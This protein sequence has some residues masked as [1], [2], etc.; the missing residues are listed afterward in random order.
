MRG[1]ILLSAASLHALKGWFIGVT[2]LSS[3]DFVQ[4][5]QVHFIS[6]S[7]LKYCRVALTLGLV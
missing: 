5:K 6:L 4:G 7:D 3:V 2:G 1:A